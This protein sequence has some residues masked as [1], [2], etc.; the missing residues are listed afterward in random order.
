MGFY[1]KMPPRIRFHPIWNLWIKEFIS[2][3]SYSIIVGHKP[4]G[5]FAPTRG[6]RQGDPLSPYIFIL[7]MEALNQMLLK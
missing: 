3:V 2:L 7:C 1:I 5:F 4:N 6:I